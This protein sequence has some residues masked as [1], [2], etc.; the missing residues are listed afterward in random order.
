MSSPIMLTGTVDV[1]AALPFAMPFALTFVAGRAHW[2]N[3]VI[4]TP[5]RCFADTGARAALSMVTE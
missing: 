3:V 1:K 2:Y 4:L 5:A